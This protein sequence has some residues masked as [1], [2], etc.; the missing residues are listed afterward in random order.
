[1]VTYNF[2]FNDSVIG[3]ITPRKGLWQGDPLSPY[4]FLLCVE[5]LSNALDV[6]ADNGT[7]T[8]C[9]I[10]LTALT[11][12]HLLFADD[13]FL[14]FRATVEE[15]TSIKELLLN[16]ESCSGQSVNFQKSGVYFSANVKHN[17]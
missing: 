5:G 4:L 16:Y 6:A 7:T 9:K 2:C 10:C 13:N 12:M 3:P 15:A 8:G 17:K 14:F 11:V 1:M